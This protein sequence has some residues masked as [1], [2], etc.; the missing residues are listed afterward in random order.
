M[1]VAESTSSS[2]GS[3]EAVNVFNCSTSIGFADV[4]MGTSCATG[5]SQYLENLAC[6]DA[7]E[8]FV[9]PDLGFLQFDTCHDASLMFISRAS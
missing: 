9:E 2:G 8:Q 6:F 7:I 1:N 4:L 3:I 5:L